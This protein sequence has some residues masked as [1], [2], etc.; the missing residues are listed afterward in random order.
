M[1]RRRRTPGIWETRIWG[2]HLSGS[3]TVIF[4]RDQLKKLYYKFK[5]T[6]VAVILRGSPGLK[7]NNAETDSKIRFFAVIF[8]VYTV[9]LQNFMFVFIISWHGRIKKNFK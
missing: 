5:S 6:K 9:N 2:P 3:R 1:Q 8:L 7:S 4:F